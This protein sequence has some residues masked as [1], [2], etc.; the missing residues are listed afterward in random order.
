MEPSHSFFR[1]AIEDS[2]A[3]LV[4]HP[5]YQTWMSYALSTNQRGHQVV[6]KLKEFSPSLEGKR[7]LDIGCGY[8]GVCISAA[9]AGAPPVGVE[10]DPRIFEFALQ[11]QKDFPDASVTFQQADI[12]D[13]QQ[14]RALGKFDVITCD[15]VIEHVAIPERLI[16]HLRLL[17]AE[18]GFAYLTIPNAFSIGQVRKDCHYG[19]WGVS[20]LDPWDAARYLKHVIENQA[21]DVSLYYPYDQYHAFFEKYGL[22][23]WLINTIEADEP[24]IQ[25]LRENSA[26][27]AEE[28][29]Q[30]L[31]SGAIPAE[32]A[33]K[34]GELV[35][36]HAEQFATS[37]AYYNDLPSGSE[38]YRYGVRLLRDY[39]EELW[40]VILAR[41]IEQYYRKT[42][43]NFQQRVA[44]K[45][46]SLLKPA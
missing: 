44:R 18:D 30:G 39:C 7:H 42:T 38:R 37:L 21:Y 5:Q 31:A 22:Q 34:L 43:P 20:L 25:S 3:S 19:L 35:R 9:L 2:Y 33:P 40:Y 24:S 16:Y 41:H 10:D 6:N 23:D 26:T 17:L 36:I 1:T 27:L 8:G 15:N 45:I 32:I 28:F 12:M 29:Q 14:V 46:K 11:N 4:D 13:L